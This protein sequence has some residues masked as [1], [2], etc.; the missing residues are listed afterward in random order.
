MAGPE[1]SL[2]SS[3][4]TTSTS[5]DAMKRSSCQTQVLTETDA[6]KRKLANSIKLA[7]LAKLSPLLASLAIVT[8]STID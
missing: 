4:T 7:S 5:L 2:R 3:R 1:T 8:R 6:K